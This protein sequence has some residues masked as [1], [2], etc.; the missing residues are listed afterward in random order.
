MERRR[1]FLHS[2]NMMNLLSFVLRITGRKRYCLRKRMWYF[3]NTFYT[4]D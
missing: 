3:Q 1:A 2:T 4:M